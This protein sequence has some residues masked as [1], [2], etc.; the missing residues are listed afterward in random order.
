MHEYKTK[1]LET[2]DQMV[3]EVRSSKSYYASM[4][5]DYTEEAF[6]SG[7]DGDAWVSEHGEDGVRIANIMLDLLDDLR[8]K[9]DELT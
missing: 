1:L 4:Q 7:R 5:Q 6:F 3:K 8:Q 2:I 9:F